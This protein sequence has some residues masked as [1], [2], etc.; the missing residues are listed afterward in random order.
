[1]EFADTVYAASMFL[2]C[3]VL[4]FVPL[5]QVIGFATFLMPN[6]IIVAFLISGLIV[7]TVFAKKI[8]IHRAVSIGKILLLC[9]T[10]IVFFIFTSNVV[11]WTAYQ[12]IYHTTWTAAQWSQ[13]MVVMLYL[14]M[15]V[16]ETMGL[17]IIA[18]GL[19]AGSSLTKI[20]KTK[21]P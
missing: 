4:L 9:S 7:G 10:I 3:Y 12:E 14:T 6:S 8:A 16:Y 21:P 15:G 5:H 17:G 18:A 13:Q 2:L 19:Y 11:D 1:M 20:R